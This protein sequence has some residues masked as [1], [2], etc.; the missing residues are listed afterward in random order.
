MQK[1]AWTWLMWVKGVGA[2][3]VGVQGLSLTGHAGDV[4]GGNLVAVSIDRPQPPTAQKVSGQLQGVEHRA[5]A[6]VAGLYRA[7]QLVVLAAVTGQAVFGPLE[8]LRPQRGPVRVTDRSLCL[9][10]QTPE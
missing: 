5:D 4:D 2:V 8:R 1:A 9:D 6:S 3:H 7:A 10:G